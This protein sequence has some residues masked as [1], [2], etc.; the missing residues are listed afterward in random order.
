MKKKKGG[1]PKEKGSPPR[2]L[3]FLRTPINTERDGQELYFYNPNNIDNAKRYC[4]IVVYHS[5]FQKSIEGDY[6][7]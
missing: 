2:N 7:R 4:S 5:G 1:D 6:K 3:L